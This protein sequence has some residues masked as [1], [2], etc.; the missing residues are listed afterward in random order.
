MKQD[1]VNVEQI[2]M[3]IRN[4]VNTRLKNSTSQHTPLQHEIQRAQVERINYNFDKN[5]IH[6]LNYPI[7]SHRKL[8]GPLIVNV[9]RT[10]R[11][12]LRWMIDPILEKQNRINNRQSAAMQDLVHE[13]NILK[14]ELRNLKGQ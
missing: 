3:E 11:K 1:V 12:A 4:K 14:A 8:L 9:K 10:I 2:M 5:E 7:T 6:T 13:I